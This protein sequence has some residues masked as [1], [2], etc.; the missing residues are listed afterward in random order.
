MD[1]QPRHLGA[2]ALRLDPDIGEVLEL[3]ALEEALPGVGDAPLHLGLVLGVAGAGRVGDEAAALEYS[4][5]P[6]V[7]TGCSGSA[8]ATAGGKL[9]MTK[10]LG[11]PPK[12]AQADSR[13][14]M[15]SSSFWLQV[16]QT[17]QCLE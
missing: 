13:P 11:M 15:T 12:K 14:A 9:S 4:R 1:A 7:K 10:Y 16:G 17:K 6:R 5:K 8:V 3:A 2:P